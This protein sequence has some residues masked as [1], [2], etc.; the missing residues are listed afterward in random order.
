MR[1]NTIGSHMI[2]M[3]KMTTKNHNHPKNIKQIT[4][5]LIR[6]S[7]EINKLKDTVNLNIRV[8]NMEDPISKNKEDAVAEDIEK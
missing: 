8:L 5:I 7:K 3:E 4:K 1:R 6:K 2:N